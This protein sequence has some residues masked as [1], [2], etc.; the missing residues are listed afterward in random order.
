MKEEN[1]PLDLVKLFYSQDI[2]FK[3]LESALEKRTT[4]AKNFSSYSLEP[5]RGD[6][7]VAQKKHLLNRTVVGM[8]KRHL[9]DLDGLS[10][11]EAIDLIF[12]EE[13]LEEP[14]NIYYHE[15]SAEEFFE[16]TGIEDVGPNQPFIDRDVNL[17][18]RNNSQRQNATWA[19]FYDGMYHQ[20]TS[21]H[22]KL[23]L[24]LH[25][26]VPVV[27][28]DGAVQI[29]KYFKLVF[30]ACFSSYK[31]FI[32]D[33]TTNPLMLEYLNLAFSK[34]ET[35]DENYAREIQELFTQGKRPTTQFT[36]E[37]VRGIARALVGWA[38]T[39][40][41]KGHVPVFRPWNHDSGDKQFSSYYNNRVIRGR[42]GDEGADELRDV[43]DMLFDTEQS[44]KYIVRRLYQFFVY[45]VVTDEIETQI[46][47]P[48]S[49]IFR[50]NNYSL[51][52]PLKV[53]LSS[54]HF[55]S[56]EIPNSIIKSPIDF[57]IGMMKEVDIKEGQ[58]YHW[59]GNR[60]I[61]ENFEP[62]FYGQK[63]K[64]P[65][66]IKYYLGQRLKGDGQNLG[67]RIQFPPSVSGWPAY[68]Q[69]PVYDLFWINS[70]TFPLRSQYAEKYFVNGLYINVR[71][72][73]RSVT[74]KADYTGYLKT[75]ENP[76]AIESFID[77]LLYRF[78]AVEISART[79]ARLKEA[80]LKGNNESHWND[81]VRNLF[82]DSPNINDY[83]NTTKRIGLTLSL[84]ATL[85]EYQLH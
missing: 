73:D 21:I 25:N 68:Y 78:L 56:R 8:A 79:R 81:E 14:T 31:D 48:L 35:P 16:Q 63:E 23:F 38:T 71:I 32:Y 27:H 61:Y 64:D 60:Y 53:L 46:I 3:S 58:L 57:T 84:I 10:L 33:V 36:E 19:V 74:L 67:M 49:L 51:V 20:N 12:T 50:D 37:D 17:D 43:V 4:A 72:E 29:H 52:E 5:Y 13:T 80:L 18:V 26:L 22:W 70:T 44:A 83:H 45:P 54:D 66:H 24:F 15:L 40:K 28:T 34:K 41:G 39:I 59:N 62:D 1:E 69:A 55:F 2:D 11:S 75:F 47:R 6:F 65:S 9:D 77:E 30:E 76:Y 42:S 85:G 7:G 82:A